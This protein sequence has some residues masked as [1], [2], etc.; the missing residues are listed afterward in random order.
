MQDQTAATRVF[1]HSYGGLIAL[2]TA[3]RTRAF[4]HVAVYE[5]AISLGGSIPTAWMPGYRQMLNDGD[6]RGAFAYFVKHSGHAPAATVKM[7]LWYLRTVMRFVVRKRQWQRM[8]PLL[9]ANLVEHEQVLRLDDTLPSYAPITAP[10]LLL[11]GANSPPFST[12]PLYEL[13]RI[14]SDSRVNVLDGL[15]HN[16]PDENALNR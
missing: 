7:P 16:A 8:E 15:G 2:E 6:T 9:H 3:K 10:V 4:T 11:G 5:P 1:G 14:L 12:Q 13:H